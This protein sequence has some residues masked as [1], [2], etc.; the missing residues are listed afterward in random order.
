M[1][2][3]LF[4]GG[5]HLLLTNDHRNY[6]NGFDHAVIA[7]NGSCE[8]ARALSEARPY[9]LN[10]RN[11]T[12]LVV[13]KGSR[14]EIDALIGEDALG[15]LNAHG[16]DG[17]LRTVSTQGSIGDCLIEE[18]KKMDADLAI[19]GGYGHSRLAEWL[20][21]GTTRTLLQRSPI[22]LLIAH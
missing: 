8:A 15:Y 11:V 18:F 3:V 17:R 10:S 20:L 2:S 21:G 9:L 5:R 22:P 16:I 14:F 19:T 12:V 4:R 6:R 13:G 1:E 7:W